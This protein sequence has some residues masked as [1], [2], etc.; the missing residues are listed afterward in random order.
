M[1]E[2]VL[3]EFED[4]KTEGKTRIRIRLVERQ[5]KVVFD[6]R[7]MINSVFMPQGLE[8]TP[9]ILPRLVV[10]VVA[11]L[12]VEAMH[13]ANRRPEPLASQS[14][15]TPTAYRTRGRGAK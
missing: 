11:M 3:A 4:L 5:G 10:Q 7:K 6:I 8:F 9:D 15:P 2:T 12:Q 13:R 14:Q 1:D